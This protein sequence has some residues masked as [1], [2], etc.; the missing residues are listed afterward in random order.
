MYPIRQAIFNED[1]V[2]EISFSDGTLKSFKLKTKTVAFPELTPLLTD[3]QL[4]LSGVVLP[5]GT[6]IYWNDDIDVPCD[7]LY[8]E[9]DLISSSIIK[10]PKQILAN[11]LIKAR[12][13]KGITQVELSR[14]TGISQ[15]DISKIER[16]L[17]NSSLETVAKLAEGLSMS[18][19]IQFK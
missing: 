3:K 18:L 4:F 11:A 13:E 15:P 8:E 17:C 2:I 14:L 19:D 6:G 1:F 9:S 12:K 16:A 10:D 5:K 7:A